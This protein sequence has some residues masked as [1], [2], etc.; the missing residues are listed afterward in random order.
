MRQNTIFHAIISQAFCYIHPDVNVLFAYI[1]VHSIA[2]KSSQAFTPTNRNMSVSRTR[3]THTGALSLVCCATALWG[4]QQ[5]MM[6]MFLAQSKETERN[7]ELKGRAE[8]GGMQ[9]KE[10]DVP[11]DF[12]KW[13]KNSNPIT[14]AGLSFVS[15]SL[16]IRVFPLCEPWWQITLGH[17]K[18]RLKSSGF[19]KQEQMVKNV[20][21]TQR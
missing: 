17:S 4:Q 13:R 12:T 7:R 10:K 6:N 3:P 2:D 11:N 18:V 15:L 14:A 21:H 1:F 8:E 5:S 9:Q 19:L 20:L 16:H